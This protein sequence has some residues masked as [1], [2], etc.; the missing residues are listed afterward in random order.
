MKLAGLMRQLSRRAS[1]PPELAEFGFESYR[2]EDYKPHT[3]GWYGQCCCLGACRFDESKDEPVYQRRRGNNRGLHP[4][5]AY[6]A[7]AFIE[8]QRK[9]LTGAA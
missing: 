7:Q 8:R 5:S 2:R 4:Y 9:L 1:V 3:R 6:C